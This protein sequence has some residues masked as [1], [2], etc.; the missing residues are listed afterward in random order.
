MSSHREA[1]EIS[2]DPVADNT[3]TYAFVSPDRPDT[4]TILT[5]YIPVE[6]AAGGPNFY[7]FGNDVRYEVHISNAGKAQ[8][9]IT[10][11]FAFSTEVLD[12]TTF[13]YNTG[14][15]TSLTDPKFNRR[16]SYSVTKTVGP[17]GRPQV[18][19]SGLAC[20][21]CNI[22]PHSTPNYT[23]L[24]KSAVHDLPDGVK[25]FAGQRNDGF[26]VDLGAVFDLADLRPF[27]T[28]HVA[29]MAPSIGVDTFKNAINV[30]T[31]A[32]QIPIRSLTRDGSV[33]NDP[34]APAAAI[35]IWGAAS[36]RKMRVRGDTTGQHTESGPWVQVSR[37]GNP[38]FNELLVTM[39]HKDGWNGSP[40]SGD[41]EYASGVE[42][43]E[44]SRRIPDLYPRQFENLRKLNATTRSDLVALILTG[45]KPGIV[46]GLANYT[47]PTL[48]DMLRLNVA[49]PPTANRKVLGVLDGD[50]AGYP[51]GRRVQDDIVTIFVRA[52][53]GA[54]RP[55]FDKTYKPDLAVGVVT[56]G[57]QTPP[58]GDTGGP[59]ERFLSHF[60]YL[61]DPYDGFTTPAPVAVNAAPSLSVPGVS[62]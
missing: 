5:N 34:G 42:K 61:G 50:P 27:Q 48:A 2:Q 19:A 38:L 3:D 54:F 25:V 36:R 51:N 18:L 16:Q 28:L 43:P 60:P 37:L 31:I 29:P 59:N 47:G 13:L 21:P 9:D 52:L 45:V 39:T 30:H 49:V 12:K 11:T 10:Y 8:A 53:T 41:A 33:P 14:A 7:E 62:P 32:L 24:A 35:G 6:A 58:T 55:Y 44:L 17:K 4:V 1:P 26:F 46:P 56:Q 57:V 20:P 23:A 40:P 15:I 22:G